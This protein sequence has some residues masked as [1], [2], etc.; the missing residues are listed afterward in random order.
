MQL[1]YHPR[2]EI[3]H[4][5]YIGDAEEDGERERRMVGCPIEMLHQYFVDL[6]SHW[7]RQLQGFLL[8]GSVAN[9]VECSMGCLSMG[10]SGSFCV[11]DSCS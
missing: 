10:F 8:G 11:T 6:L 7:S 5:E 9:G 3:H 4:D 1:G 2:D